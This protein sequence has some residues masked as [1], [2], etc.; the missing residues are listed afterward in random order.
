MSE[1]TSRPATAPRLSLRDRWRVN[2]YLARVNEA[3][4]DLMTPTDFRRWHATRSDL[5]AG[6]LA[7]ASDVGVDQALSDLGPAENLAREYDLAIRG[8]RAPLWTRGVVAAMALL[9]AL[10]LV[11]FAFTTGVARG[12]LYA[13]GGDAPL[14]NVLGL[15]SQPFSDGETFGVNVNLTGLLWWFLAALIV[16]LLVAKVWRLWRR[17]VS[18]R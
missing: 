4:P 6:L 5:R 16:F 18:T 17:P 7:A 11:W 9:A 13:G 1:D 2:R 12:L 8:P 14:I 10:A 3:L 15:R